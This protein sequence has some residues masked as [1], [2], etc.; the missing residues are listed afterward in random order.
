M[1][2]RDC[3]TFLLK[4]VRG[5]RK[6]LQCVS[7]R[8]RQVSFCL[9]F[10][11]LQTSG[12]ATAETSRR[13]ARNRISKPVVRR[14]ESMRLGSQTS[15]QALKS[16]PKRGRIGRGRSVAGSTS[17]TIMLSTRCQ[18]N[19]TFRQIDAF[20]PRRDRAQTGRG[21]QSRAK[22]LQQTQ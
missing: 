21:D 20:F 13:M 5:A 1:I 17:T 10:N 9:F 7:I 6:T 12:W 14:E 11:N 19:A 22:L 15:F 4:F 2:L 18:P 3:Q 16:P 8:T